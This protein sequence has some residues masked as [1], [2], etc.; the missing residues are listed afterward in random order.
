MQDAIE[1]L[2]EYGRCHEIPEPEWFRYS[3]SIGGTCQL[4]GTPF[5]D[6]EAVC[7]GGYDQLIHQGCYES[8]EQDREEA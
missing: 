3:E 4:C 1:R 5:R 2:E 6:G 8:R 7:E